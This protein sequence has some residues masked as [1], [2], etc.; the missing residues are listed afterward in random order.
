[1]WRPLTAMGCMENSASHS[2][3]LAGNSAFY[4]GRL[5][6][7]WAIF[8]LAFLGPACIIGSGCASVE[9]QTVPSTQIHFVQVPGST[10]F[11]APKP[12]GSPKHSGGRLT[13]PSYRYQVANEVRVLLYPKMFPA[14][15][16][17]EGVADAGNAVTRLTTSLE[18]EPAKF[19]NRLDATNFLSL[20][21][22]NQVRL[23]R[24]YEKP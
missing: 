9:P 11:H 22:T 4:L 5:Y 7:L 14:E 13:T 6:R 1:M 20:L 12:H 18:E 24:L 15:I 19:V 16:S 10:Q 17:L 2:V 21:T 23:C 3:A 8:S